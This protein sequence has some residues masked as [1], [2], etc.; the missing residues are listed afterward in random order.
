MTELDE[1]ILRAATKGS[2][3]AFKQLY[4]YYAPFVWRLAYKTVAGDESL[5]RQ[6]AQDVFVRV[7]GSLRRFDFRSGFSTWLYRIA[8]N[9]A[10]TL[11]KRRH[12]EW[13]RTV[14][15]SDELRASGGEGALDA[16]D[17]VRQV[18]AGLSPDE[19]FLLV[20]REVD[21]VPFE[22]L[23]EIAGK[24]SG[25]LRT[26]LTRLKE[27]LRKEYDHGRQG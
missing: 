11:L 5:A 21:G 4:D 25:A 13:Q 17:T 18:L 9:Q 2:N 26:Q 14:G 23:A 19:R 8:Y 10:L 1:S 15:L 22:E 12:I 3:T 20:A 6:V 16:R 24:T 7:H 27:S